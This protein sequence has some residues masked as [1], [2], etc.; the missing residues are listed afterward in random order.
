MKVVGSGAVYFELDMD[1]SPTHL[2]FAEPIVFGLEK[3]KQ[4]ST[5][6]VLGA[7]SYEAGWQF[8]RSEMVRIGCPPFSQGGKETTEIALEKYVSIH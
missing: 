5:S 2:N 7:G 6:P 3:N 1:V 8:T 4:A